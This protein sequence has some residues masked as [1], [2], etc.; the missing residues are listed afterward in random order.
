MQTTGDF[1]GRAWI[2]ADMPRHDER[3]GPGVVSSIEKRPN[4]LRIRVNMANAGRVVISET[5]WKGW[6]A[7]IDGR[8][9]QMQIADL[10]FLAVYV[11][12]GA[13]SIR[14]VYLPDS[15]VTGRAITVATLIALILAAALHRLQ[16][17]LQRRDRRVA[18]LPLGQ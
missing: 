17:F 9:V 12:A 5:A 4:G 6:R 8:R 13:H 3:N 2:D 11:P 14:L 7:Y 10:A 18:A 15:F 16:L 1:G